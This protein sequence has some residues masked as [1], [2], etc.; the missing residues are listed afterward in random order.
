MPLMAMARVAV[1]KVRRLGVVLDEVEPEATSLKPIHR[2]KRIELRGV[3]HKY[4]RE[5]EDRG[6]QLGPI[7][8]ELRL[9]EIVFVVGGNGSGKTT[10]IKLF[11][12]LY[13][14]EQGEI[15]LDDQLIDADNRESYRQLFS[16]VFDNAVL[17]DRLMGLDAADLDGR[18]REY[19]RELELDHVVDVKKGV[20]STTELSR[21]QRKRL[22]LLTAYLEDRAIY[23]FDEWAA[24]QDP[25]F[26]R[27]FY[28]K[29]LYDLR[30]SGKTVLAITHDDRYFDAADRVIK[31]EDGQV[32]EA[33]VEAMRCEP[34]LQKG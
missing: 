8:M 25:V 29:L 1:E 30:N 4:H 3:T 18:A 19:L 26:K 32:A 5:G 22:A 17:F 14:P 12:G 31:L 28:R 6:F 20:F 16:A 33:T 13:V 2:W 24:D 27:L 34:L 11:T 23:I 9:G 7:D 15:H 21:G 10:L